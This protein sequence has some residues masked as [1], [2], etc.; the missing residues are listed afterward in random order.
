VSSLS[1]AG[2]GGPYPAGDS[3]GPREQ[4]RNRAT[5][6]TDIVVL[7]G[8]GD[9]ITDRKGREAVILTARDQITVT[10]YRL[11]HGAGIEHTFAHLGSGKTRFL[12][13]HAP[14]AGFA[15]FLRRVS[16]G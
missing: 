3:L 6:P 7:P 10:R 4:D 8:E 1:S 2:I 14:D 5:N 11:G 16:Q 15:A 12:N 9:T 13:L